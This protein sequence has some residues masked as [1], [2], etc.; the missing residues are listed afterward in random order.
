MSAVTVRIPTPLRTFTDGADEI[1]VQGSNVRDALLE[2]VARHKELD[3]QLFK[4]NGELRDFIN[5]FLGDTNIRS[6]AGLD[7]PIESAEVLN[8]VPAVAGGR[9]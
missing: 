4:T 8:I 1:P 5:I 2:L 3:R 6:L 7:S 9:L